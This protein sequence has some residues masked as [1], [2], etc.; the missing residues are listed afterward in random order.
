MNT[1]LWPSQKSEHRRQSEQDIEYQPSDYDPLKYRTSRH[2]KTSHTFQYVPLAKGFPRKS[3]V[4]CLTKDCLIPNSHAN[5][6]PRHLKNSVVNC[7]MRSVSL[8]GSSTTVDFIFIW[9]PFLVSLWM[10]HS[11]HRI[12]IQ[13]LKYFYS[14]GYSAPAPT[15][16]NSF[17]PVACLPQPAERKVLDFLF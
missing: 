12:R 6:V 2:S 16:G 10:L 4:P 15:F 13:V 3:T 5:A 1:N 14:T 8:F 9:S 11:N 17:W 7:A